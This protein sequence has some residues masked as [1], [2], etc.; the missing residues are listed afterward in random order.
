MPPCWIVNIT[1]NSKSIHLGYYQNKKEAVLA[2]N[3]AALKLHGEFGKYKV[4]HNLNK[5]KEDGLL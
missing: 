1:V 5:L 3:D 4:T 2:Y